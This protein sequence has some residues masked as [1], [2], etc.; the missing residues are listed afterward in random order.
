LSRWPAVTD[1]LCYI[2]DA[3]VAPDRCLGVDLMCSALAVAATATACSEPS[4][5]LGKVAG[6]PMSSGEPE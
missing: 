3:L 6:K 5:E 2:H 1:L 4:G